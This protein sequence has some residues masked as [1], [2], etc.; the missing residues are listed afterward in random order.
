MATQ[1]TLLS[2]HLNGD[3][4]QHGFSTRSLHRRGAADAAP[5]NSGRQQVR[6]LHWVTGQPSDL[7]NDQVRASLDNQIGSSVLELDENAHVLTQEEYY[8]FGGTA[9]WSGKNSSETKYKFLRYS[10]K[11]RDATGLYYYG[12]RYYVPGPGRW[13]NPD[14]ADMV[15]G[16]NLFRMVRNNPVN[17]VDKPGLMG[18]RYDPGTNTFASDGGTSWLT[19][20]RE[21]FD[22]SDHGHHQHHAP[23]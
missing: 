18:I 3:I 23:Q 13:I 14:P 10:G 19:L 20:E 17:Y 11:E 1:R 7:P 2:D 8:P 5:H 21:S 15:D 9:V 4:Q 16:L 22:G 12:L 6:L